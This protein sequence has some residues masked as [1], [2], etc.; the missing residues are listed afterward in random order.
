[1]S[2]LLFRFKKFEVLQSENVFK[3]GTDAVL[4]GVATNCDGAAN[5]L[6]VGTG[7]GLI[8]LM[9]AQRSKAYI[10]AIDINPEACLLAKKNVENSVFHDRITVKNSSLQKYFPDIKFDLIISN[11]PYFT[12][13]MIAPNKNRALARH[14]IELSINDFVENSYRL[15][16]DNG[17]VAVILPD[18]QSEEYVKTS[19]NV[20]LFLRSKLIIFPKEGMRPVRIITEMSKIDGDISEKSLTIEKSKRHDYTEEYI[21]LTADYYL[22]F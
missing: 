11:P 5:I 2:E 15:L 20:G 18:K 3:I 10:Y 8:A 13:G 21:N 22:K 12:S 19:V 6:D 1:M 4:L 16:S 7:T 14:D 9:L 17:R